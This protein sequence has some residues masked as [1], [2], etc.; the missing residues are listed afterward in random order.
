MGPRETGESDPAGQSPS[1]P[2]VALR[3]EAAQKPIGTVA[4]PLGAEYKRPSA[5]VSDVST[6]SFTHVATLDAPG[7]EVYRHLKDRDLK[8]RE[9]MFIAEG[10]EVV[11]RLLR[12][13]FR[14]HSLLVTPG[15]LERLLPDLPAGGRVFIA[16]QSQMEEI[17]GFAI[18]RGAVAC[19]FRRAKPDLET[20]LTAAGPTG[21]VVVIEKVR[22][23]QNV[24]L[25][26]RSAAAFHASL[27]VTCGCCDPFYRRAIRVSMGNVFRLPIY[28]TNDAV[29]DL[30]ILRRRL[31]LTLIAAEVSAQAVPL[32]T[33]TRPPRTALLL[34]SEG[35]G[36]SD[37]LLA[38]CDHRVVIPVDRSSDSLNVAT[39]AGIF[40]YTLAEPP[41][42]QTLTPFSA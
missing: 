37:E 34:G 22:D 33:I 21:T 25:V 23:A 11:R 26:I 12:S 19:G 20:A 40:L 41:A 32:H 8:C 35:S 36:L 3:I 5:G 28:D 38:I 27:I 42:P 16:D 29:S 30:Q 15:K 4:Y 17:A 9:G 10:L 7:L 2:P 31:G 13:D 24:G 6:P 1:I 39:A 18:H 14:I